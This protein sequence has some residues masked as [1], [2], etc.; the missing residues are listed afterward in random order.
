MRPPWCLA[1]KT[2]KAYVQ[3]SQRSVGNHDSALQG[4]THNFT[5]SKSQCRGSSLNSTWVTHEGESL[6]DFRTHA[7]GTGI[8]YNVLWGWK[9]WQASFFFFF[10]S[11]STYLAWHWC[12]GGSHV[13]HSCTVLAPLAPPHSSQQTHPAQP[14]CSSHA[15]LKQLPAP[16]HLEEINEIKTK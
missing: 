2:S 8:C 3:E 12:P 10:Y 14:T 4:H 6:T 5:P 11:P 13:W 15:L 7:K 1:L 9:F 16:S